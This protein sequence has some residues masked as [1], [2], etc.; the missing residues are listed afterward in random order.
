MNRKDQSAL[1]RRR[2]NWLVNDYPRNRP[3]VLLLLR[4]VNA[5]GRRIHRKAVHHRLDREVFKLPEV[6]RIVLLIHANHSAGT[7]RVSAAEDRIELDDIGALASGRFARARCRSKANT[8]RVL[9]PPQ[10]RN[11]R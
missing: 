9:L 11:A 8:V 2:L 4:S 5:M 3:A 6:I 10:S 1:S 7:S